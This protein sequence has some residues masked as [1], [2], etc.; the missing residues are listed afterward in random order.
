MVMTNRSDRGSA[1]PRG[2]ERYERVDLVRD[3]ICGLHQGQQACR[4]ARTGRTHGCTRLARI[5]F[6]IPCTA[7]AVHTCPVKRGKTRG[8]LQHQGPWRPMSHCQSAGS[9]APSTQ[10]GGCSTRVLPAPVKRVKIR[11]CSV[12]THRHSRLSIQS[13]A[14]RS[15]KPNESFLVRRP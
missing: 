5:A 1:K 15:A 11:R 9:T 2:A 13:V 14:C 12:G 4:P 7:V 10:A 8:R 6:E 3:P